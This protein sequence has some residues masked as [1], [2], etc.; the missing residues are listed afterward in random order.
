MCG[1]Y[2]LEEVIGFN[3]LNLIKEKMDIEAKEQPHGD[4][5]GADS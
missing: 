4:N 5:I 1:V 2:C 3:I